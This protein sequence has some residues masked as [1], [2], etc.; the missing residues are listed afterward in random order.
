MP[1]AFSTAAEERC[2]QVTQ[3]DLAEVADVAPVTIRTR[4]DELRTLADNDGD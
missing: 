1:T 2:E 3:A 4:W